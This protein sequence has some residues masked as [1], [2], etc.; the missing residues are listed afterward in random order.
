MVGRGFVA[1]FTVTYHTGG[2]YDPAAEEG[3]RWDDP[4]FG[5]C[6]PLPVTVVSDRDAAWPWVRSRHGRAAERN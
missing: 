5:I 4:D 6:W 2:R 3:F 1:V